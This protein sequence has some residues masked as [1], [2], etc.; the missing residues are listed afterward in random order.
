MSKLNTYITFCGII[1]ILGSLLSCRKEGALRWDADLLFPIAHGRINLADVITDTLLSTDPDGLVHLVYESDWIDLPLDSLVELPDTAVINSFSPPFSGG[2]FTIP[3]GSNL[4]TLN[5]NIVLD[6]DPAQLK[7]VRF[8]EGTLRYALRSYVNG[9]LD[10]SYELPGVD[11]DNGGFLLET[12]SEPGTPENPWEETGELDLEGV[13]LL[14]TGDDGLSHNSVASQIVVNASSSVSESL[15]VYGEDSVAVELEFLGAKVAYAKGYFGDYTSELDEQ[16]ELQAAISAGENGLLLP[17]I[18]FDLQLENYFGADVQL[19]I[20]TL[21]GIGN[22]AVALEHQDFNGPINIAR[23]LDDNATVIPTNWS[24]A[25]DNSNSNI[26][27]W[28]A[29]VPD[30][31]ALLA[32]LDLN[33]LGDISGGNDFFY[34]AHPPRAQFNLDIPLCINAEELQFRDTLW[35]ND[36]LELPSANGKIH[37]YVLNT[38]PFSLDLQLTMYSANQV[39]LAEIPLSEPISSAIYVNQLEPN[40]SVQ[41]DVEFILEDGVLEQIEPNAYFVITSQV[42]GYEQ[43]EVKLDGSEYIDVK[44]IADLETEMTVE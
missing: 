37:L 12:T 19:N 2:P 33:P 14:L 43:F 18:S 42:S 23:A 29:N 22:Q 10:V 40:G 24:I 30:S 3:S 27:E 7:L 21:E 41:S 44:I 20:Q 36:N 13:T 16:F 34:A 39:L 25:M 26:V 38:F 11:E 15:E 9:Y 1:L 28:I 8:S 6:A 35:I 31:V 32:N 4:I 5:D 17:G